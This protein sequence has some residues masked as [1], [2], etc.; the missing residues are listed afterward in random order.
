MDE[1]YGRNRE[2][3]ILKELFSRRSA[4]LVIIRGRRRIGKSR[5]AEKF[6]ESFP[7]QFTFVGLP[8]EKNVT[9]DMERKHFVNDMERQTG[10]TGLRYDDWDFLFHN[11]AQFTKSGRVLIIFDEINWM[12]TKDPTFLGKLKTAWDVH[13]KKN[14]ELIMIL[15]GSMSTWIEKNILSSTGYFGRVELDIIL[16]E[17]PLYDCNHFWRPYEQTVAPYEKFKLLC[18]TGGVPRY[19]ESID[20][21]SSAEENIRRLF[22]RKEGLFFKEF[23]RIF[24]DLF[25]NKSPAYKAIIERLA[26]GPAELKEIYESLGRE[27][28]GI[29]SEYLNDLEKTGYV[30]RDY[31][32]K[33]KEG[34]YQTISQFRLSDNYLRF[35]LKYIEPYKEDILHDRENI[36]SNWHSIMGLQFENLV[37]NNRK[38]I[39]RLLGIKPEEIKIDNPYFQ[40][41]TARQPG[42]QIDYMIQTKFNSLYLIEI[43]FKKE[44]IGT[45]VIGEIKEKIEKLILPRGYSLRTV[46]IHVNG[47][48]ESVEES[49]FFSH[50]IDFSQLLENPEIM[51]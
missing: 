49:N 17:L 18:V 24:S 13:F 7:K 11:L 47:V 22:Y 19:L 51:A 33:L 5:L 16:K 30:S 15:S 6:C 39:Y 37:L 29:Y 26:E 3:K 14:P 2:L 4:S 46:L 8:P 31:T 27:K 43:K 25:F 9:A 20:P 48:S 12:G 50:I 21:K 28:S 45:E 44:K 1:F 42:V 35:Y 34:K 38:S 40:H 10:L 36:P 23:D 41:K 32:W